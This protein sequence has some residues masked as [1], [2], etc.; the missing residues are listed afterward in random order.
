MPVQSWSELD[1]D[2]LCANASVFGFD[3]DNTLASSKQPMKPEMIAR[4]SEL[5]AR[6]PV[7]LISG[8]SMAVV[9]M[10][11]LDVLNEHAVKSNL[12]VMPTS[13]SRYYRWLD[14]QW[15]LIYAHDL[16]QPTVAAIESS[17]E[18]HARELGLWEEQVWGPRI[19][20]RGSQITFSALGQYAPVEV[21]QHWD[22]DDSKKQALCALVSQDFPD[23]RVR[24]GGY[25]SV[26]V[27]KHGID[28]AYAVRK[29]A[30][31]MSI[32]V[33]RIVFVGDRMSPGGNDYPAVM[34]GA[35][36]AAVR[37]PQ[38][39]LGLLDAVLERIPAVSGSHVV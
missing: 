9:T 15:T 4:F 34:A 12:H 1:L 13:G 2:E 10:Q 28:K 31:V 38:D 3:L 5:T 35:R 37:N 29:L 8:G 7:A 39:T 14:N 23:L 32:N 36:G 11:V 18:R 6:I 16:D 17:L 20:N 21:K 24:T 19:E 26:D 33:D 25:S 27:S 22:P 30:S